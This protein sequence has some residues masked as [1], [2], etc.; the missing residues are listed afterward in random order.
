MSEI[1][2]PAPREIIPEARSER[3]K[4]SLTKEGIRPSLL[5]SSTTDTI[6]PFF[7]SFSLFSFREA[8]K[9]RLA[10]DP[11]LPFL[12]RGGVSPAKYRNIARATPT[13]FNFTRLPLVNTNGKEMEPPAS[14][15]LS[16]SRLLLSTRR[17]ILLHFSLATMKYSW[18]YSTNYI[19]NTQT[20]AER[21][22]EREER[23]D[24]FSDWKMA[25]GRELVIGVSRQKRSSR[26]GRRQIDRSPNDRSSWRLGEGTGIHCDAARVYFPFAASVERAL[27]NEW[28]TGVQSEARTPLRDRVMKN[29]HSASPTLPPANRGAL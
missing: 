16:A 28:A 26:S 9:F 17:P 2:K 11:P 23:S 8:K 1:R 5:L 12:D 15:P 3:V 13:I 18:K 4:L 25:K 14:F 6:F 10:R 21:E 20:F 27:Q 24:D 22:R 29:K 19:E 7:P